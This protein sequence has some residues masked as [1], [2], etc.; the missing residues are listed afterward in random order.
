MKRLGYDI[1]RLQKPKV[2]IMSQLQLALVSTVL[3]IHPVFGVS[4]LFEV[5]M[6]WQESP[7][8]LFRLCLGSSIGL[9]DIAIC[10]T[11]LAGLA[12]IH[13]N[14]KRYEFLLKLITLS[15]GLN[16]TAL[17]TFVVLQIRTSSLEEF[18]RQTCSTK[19]RDVATVMVLFL[20]GF[21][22]LME[23]VVIVTHLCLRDHFTHPRTSYSLRRKS[24]L[25]D[26]GSS[27]KAA[28]TL[29]SSDISLYPNANHR[30]HE[31]QKTGPMSPTS[32]YARYTVQPLA[33][34]P[35]NNSQ[36]RSAI[37][38]GKPASPMHAAVIDE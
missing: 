29:D 11:S 18:I 15:L 10:M 6:I 14:R 35:P 21:S 31:L 17:I 38:H 12:K 9:M 19:K 33:L 3:F 2:H 24:V 8:D 22:I 13:S 23:C 25:L 5:F 37:N 26:S 30:I 28:L 32:P 36:R 4:I 34:G 7:S 27:H 16:A 20:A 1:N